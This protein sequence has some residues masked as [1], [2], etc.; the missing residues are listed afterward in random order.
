MYIDFTE[1]GTDVQIDIW[2]SFTDTSVLSNDFDGCFIDAWL[3]QD[4]IVIASERDVNNYGSLSF[5]LPSRPLTFYE[6]TEPEYLCDNFFQ[7]DANQAFA[8]LPIF[9]LNT[10]IG[11]THGESRSQI[12]EAVR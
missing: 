10:T 3:T 9:G 4:A 7:Y 2:G 11:F 1:V 8:V 6:V 12:F 5:I